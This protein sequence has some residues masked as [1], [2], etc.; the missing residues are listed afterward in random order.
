[1]RLAVHAQNPDG[2]HGR[3]A[4]LA[5]PPAGPFRGA[6]QRPVG[7]RDGPAGSGRRGAVPKRQAI[8]GQVADVAQA[9]L[10]CRA[11]GKSTSVWA[12]VLT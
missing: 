9:A 3:V 1:M 4:A 5:M 11:A 12:T 6:W 2:T 7:A 10:R 8:A